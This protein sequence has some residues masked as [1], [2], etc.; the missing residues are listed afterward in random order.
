MKR[1]GNEIAIIMQ[2]KDTLIRA[3]VFFNLPV[4]QKA[5]YQPYREQVHLLIIKDM[6]QKALFCQSTKKA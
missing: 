5:E 4:F 6:I 3:H 2:I 1:P